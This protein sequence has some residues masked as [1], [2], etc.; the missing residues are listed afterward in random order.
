MQVEIKIPALKAL[1]K[2]IL[3]SLS[4]CSYE[5]IALKSSAIQ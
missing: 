1:R 4:K 2:L 3:Q 5:I